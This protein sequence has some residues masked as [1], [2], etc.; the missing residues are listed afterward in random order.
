[1][2]AF[3]SHASRDE[4]AVDVVR[5]QVHALGVEVYLAEHDQRAGERLSQKVEKALRESDIVIAVLTPAGYD[6]RYV[7]QE[8][9]LARGTGRL[10]VPLV[11]PAIVGEDLGLLNDIEYIVFD[12]SR[13]QEGLASLTERVAF[14]ARQQ[15]AREDLTWAAIAIVGAMVLLYVSQTS[16]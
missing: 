8:L 1:M 5:E 2:R 13:P 3:I 6:S 14:L 7:Q 9:G 12:P 15:H 16:S 10:V 4:L 11:H